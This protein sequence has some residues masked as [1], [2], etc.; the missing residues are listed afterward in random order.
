MNKKI[1]IA[2]I[3]IILT[4]TLFAKRLKDIDPQK[5]ET[6]KAYLAAV[7]QLAD[8]YDVCSIFITNIQ[9]GKEFIMQSSRNQGA[10]FFEIPEGEYMIR[11]INGT[12]G[13]FSTNF[14]VSSLMLPTLKIENG[15]IFFLGKFLFQFTYPSMLFKEYLKDDAKVLEKLENLNITEFNLSNWHKNYPKIEGSELFKIPEPPNWVF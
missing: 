4:T 7:L 10:R 8:R 13:N 15:T 14:S 1:Q 6:D 5:M 11:T 12:S 9:T 2:L 3:L